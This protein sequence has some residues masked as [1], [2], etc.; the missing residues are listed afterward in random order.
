[1]VAPMSLNAIAAPKLA[2]VVA[3]HLEDQVMAMGWPVGEVLGSENELLERFGVSRSV[4]REAIRIV[5]HGG[6]ARMRRGP[7]GGLVVAAPNRDAVTTS[8]SIWFSYVGVTVGEMFDAR[9]PLVVEAIRDAAERR[10][11]AEVE[12]VR[13]RIAEMVETGAL[14]AEAFVDL[15]QRFTALS[16]NPVAI[17]FADALSGLLASRLRSGRARVEPAVTDADALRHLQ[18]YTRLADEVAAGDVDGAT[19]RMRRILVSV[20]PR[21][22]DSPAPRGRQVSGIDTASPKLA[23]RVV[24]ALRDDIEEA[25][26]PIDTVLG[27]EPELIERYEVSRAILREAVRVLE[28]D[29]AVRTKR[30]PGGGLMVTAPDIAAIVRAVG[31]A[32]EYERV[33]PKQLVDV[34]SALEVA[35]VRM[36][37]TTVTSS[38]AQD[39]LSAVAAERTAGDSAIHLHDI[40]HRIADASGCRPLALFV[41]VMSDLVRRHMEAEA[42]EG[43][44][45]PAIAAQTHQAHLRIAEAIA[46]GDVDLAERRMRRH[47]AAVL[48]VLH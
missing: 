29:G 20:R 42:A 33:T 39:L 14:D 32:L 16:D 44:A 11:L 27:S 10:P 41:R 9:L 22:V 8:I 12:A 5:E 40:H 19:E 30:G 34:R 3:R 48:D 23:E 26:W 47:L 18:A 6:A 25:G 45:L 35:A 36:T 37:A 43:H 46:A 2:T 24:L 38:G 4:L 7:G 31:L 13:R 17:L 21:L 1:V 15:D 28:H